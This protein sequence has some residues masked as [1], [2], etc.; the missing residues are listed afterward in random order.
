MKKQELTGLAWALFF[1]IIGIM[2]QGGELKISVTAR[3]VTGAV[4][5]IIALAAAWREATAGM[6]GGNMISAFLMGLSV[7]FFS[8]THIIGAAAAVIGIAAIAIL[9]FF[10][11]KRA[12]TEELPNSESSDDIYDK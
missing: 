11:G 4:F 8:I 2:F 3:C 9:K 1:C 6:R 5:C 10:L 7:Y 12:R